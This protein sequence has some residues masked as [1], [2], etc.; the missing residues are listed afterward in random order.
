LLH[1]Q[2]VDQVQAGADF[3]VV[4]DSPGSKYDKAVQLK[5]SILDDAGFAVLLEQGP[6]AAREAAREATRML[7]RLTTLE[8]TLLG[9]VR[10]PLLALLAAV[11]LLLLENSE[12]SWVFY[13]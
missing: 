11:G 2:A 5:L 13:E 6:E 10:T 1:H 7:K 3:V 4:G 12:L 8:R 9:S